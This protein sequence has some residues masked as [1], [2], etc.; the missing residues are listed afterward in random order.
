MKESHGYKKSLH[1]A[2]EA[3]EKREEA[4][5]KRHNAIVERAFHTGKNIARLKQTEYVQYKIDCTTWGKHGCQKTR[6]SL[7]A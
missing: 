6:K 5:R 7:A 2:E 3:K 4:L 1:A